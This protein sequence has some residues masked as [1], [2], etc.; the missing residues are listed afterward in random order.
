MVRCSV[1]R[2]AASAVGLLV[3]WGNEA[4]AGGTPLTTI[5]VTSGLTSPLFVTHAPGDTDRIFIIEQPGRIRILDISVEPP[6]LRGTPFLDI[7]SRVRF[8]GERGLLGMAFHPDFANNGFFYVNYTSLNGVDG[9][10]RVS[11]FH[12]PP[13]VP[14]QADDSSELFLLEIAQPQ[15]NHNGGWLAFGPDGYLY[16]ATGDGG[17]FNDEGPGHTTG[18]GNGQD[19]TANLLGKMLRIDVDTDDFPAEAQRNYGIPPSNPFVGITG[20]DEIWAYGLRNPW[21]NAFDSLTGDLYIADVGQGT[22]EEVD[23]QASDSTGGENWGWRCREGAHNFN[24]T[25]DC[26][27]DGTPSAT[28][29][30]PIHEYSHGGSP[31]RCSITGGEVYRGCAIPDLQ[32]TYFFADFCSNQI[33]SFAFTGA[34]PVA[35][36]RTTELDPV[37]FSIGGVTSFGLDAFGEMYICDSNDGEVFKIVPDGA[38]SQC[39]PIGVEV[40]DDVCDQDGP[41]QPCSTND[42]CPGAVCGLKSRYISFTPSSFLPGEVA[43]R[44]RAMSLPDYPGFV[45]EDRWVG[46]PEQA[47]DEDNSDPART[48][49]VAKLECDP[50]LADWSTVGLVNVYGGEIVPGG[51]YEVRTADAACVA[52]GV[53]SCMSAPLVVGTGKWADVVEPF[54]EN[55]GDVEPSFLDVSAMVA[56]FLGDPAAPTKSRSQLL[57][58]VV[59]PDRT[60][61][62]RDISGAVGSFL[63]DTFPQAS[64]I[65][66]PCVCPSTT[67]CGA[68]ACTLDTDCAGGFCIDSFCFDACAR[69]AP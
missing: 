47:N 26:G 20:D 63:G 62:F 43:L 14:N 48:F 10:T 36:E 35:E 46:L 38:P 3:I 23:F 8:G 39:G 37:G 54:F 66:G 64:G 29:L 56:K 67:A 42:D 4:V 24:F 27:V 16:I 65:T 61:S 30:D 7:T 41:P 21:R 22:W 17:R 15:A 1:V 51:L 55:I 69:C 50:V 9:D 11:R 28:L 53:E 25:G 31:F 58:N 13:G 32:G 6:V 2:C 18:T 59:F 34:A 45:G 33:W 44:V 49:T 57:P 60:V 68:T 40:G 12:V 19:I 5:R 52:A